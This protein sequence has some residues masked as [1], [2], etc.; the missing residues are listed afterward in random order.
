[1]MKRQTYRVATLQD[2]AK[3]LVPA[4]Y[5][6][7]QLLEKT[8]AGTD[9]DY[10]LNKGRSPRQLRLYF[11]LLGKCVEATD[12]FPYPTTEAAH[13]A[14]KMALGYVNR[15][16]DLKAAR[17]VLT[18]KSVA[19]H[20]MP[21]DEFQIFFDRAQKLVFEQWLQCREVGE[22]QLA[23]LNAMLDRLDNTDWSTRRLQGSRS[24]AHG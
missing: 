20:Q 5:E 15:V 7:E 12:G 14:I 17:Y 21:Q 19:M 4:C 9:L 16:W 2:G 11:S 6:A 23:E 22:A 1:M 18:P 8:K 13:D 24:L 10:S 3:V